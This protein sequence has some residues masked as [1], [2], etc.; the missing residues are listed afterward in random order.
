M[1][2]VFYM[3]DENGNVTTTDNVNEWGLWFESADRVVAQETIDGCKISTVF[4]GL[5]FGWN[6]E[7][8]KLWETMVFYGEEFGDVYQ[9]R[10]AGTK[11]DAQLMHEEAVKWVLW[12][13]K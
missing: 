3:L 8:P 5:N 11:K 4:L 12:K 2:N 9:K 13:S 1:K 10:C 6:D 7:P